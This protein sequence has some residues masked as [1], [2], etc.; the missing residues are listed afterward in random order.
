MINHHETHHLGEY[1]GIV[2]PFASDM[3][4]QEAGI[5]SFWGCNFILRSRTFSRWLIPF[6]GHNLE[7]GAR[8]I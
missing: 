1:V 6:E 5:G 2:V 7:C 8:K 4:I 3:Q